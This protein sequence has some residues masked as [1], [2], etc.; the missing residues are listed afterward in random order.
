MLTFIDVNICCKIWMHTCSCSARS[1][2]SSWLMSIFVFYVVM[3][4]VGCSCSNVLYST[5]ILCWCNIS[6]RCVGSH[7]CIL[8][9]IVCSWFLWLIVITQ[10]VSC[11][12]LLLLLLYW[13]KAFEKVLCFLHYSQWTSTFRIV[14]KTKFENVE[15]IIF[16][17]LCLFVIVQYFILVK[18]YGSNL[19]AKSL[20]ASDTLNSYWLFFELTV[21]YGVV[22]FKPFPCI[23]YSDIRL[24][25]KDACM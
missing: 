18:G 5:R 9:H 2:Q 6:V 13:L 24:R 14:Q 16:C 1:W 21:F 8:K 22:L 19:C 12:L 7:S 4:N 20:Y 10:Y 3:L 23:F 17:N 15:H 25:P 11:K